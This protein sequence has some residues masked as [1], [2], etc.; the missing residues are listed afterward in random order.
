[1]IDFAGDGNDHLVVDSD[2]GGAG[3]GG[4]SFYIF[5]LLREALRPIVIVTSEVNGDEAGIVN[6]EIDVARTRRNGAKV[7]CFTE[8]TTFNPKK[9]SGKPQVSHPCYRPGFGVN[10]D[11]RDNQTWLREKPQ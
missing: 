11:E 3:V 6:S 8:N 1:M 4:S 10:S 5:D 7:F 9:P 2:W